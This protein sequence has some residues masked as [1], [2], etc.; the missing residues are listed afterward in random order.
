MEIETN[1]ATI[2]YLWE[3]L[4]TSRLHP[5]FYQA[6]HKFREEIKRGW[7]FA[8]DLEDIL[9]LMDSRLDSHR[10]RIRHFCEPMDIR[11]EDVFYRPKLI[12]TGAISFEALRPEYFV[13]LL[14]Q[15]ERM[16]F[17]VDAQRF[18]NILLPSVKPRSKKIFSVAE[19]E[20]FWYGKS[21][22]KQADVLLF[23]DKS[24]RY[25]FPDRKIKLAGGFKLSLGQDEG[26]KPHFLTIRAPKYRER[27]RL[28]EVTCPECG[29]EWRKGDA[30]SSYC[31]RR[32][33]RKRMA[34]LTPQP[35]PEMVAE[36]TKK[37]IAAELVVWD[38]QPWKQREMYKRAQ[39]FRR[40]FHYDF[41]QWGENMDGERDAHG[42]LFTN[43]R[44]EIVGACSFRDRSE[45]GIQR[46]GLQW[47]WI[48]PRERR[49]GHLSKRWPALREQF[50]DFMV[51]SPVSDA[52]QAFLE[53]RGEAFLM[54]HER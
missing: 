30:E 6:E 36:L 49:S 18:V 46:W 50:G 24:R 35:L 54:H 34:W 7:I 4:Q 10:F 14:I 22:L 11:F 1:S 3:A 37:G 25:D 16:G 31:H 43:E 12:G 23:S 51:E 19:L 17:Q 41:V 38:S 15:L 33:H 42:Y 39:A 27:R 20:I 52:M 13:L 2:Q 45:D 9:I 5:R 40:E 28:R 8:S 26:Q 44:S 53:K 47:V 32:E 29:Y 48:C 21:R